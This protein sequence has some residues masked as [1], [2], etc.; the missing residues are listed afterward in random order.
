MASNPGCLI[1]GLYTHAGGF[2]FFHVR[3]KKGQLE[4]GR[5]YEVTRTATVERQKDK[6]DIC[7]CPVSRF[8]S[9]E[10]PGKRSV[11]EHKKIVDTEV[12]TWVKS[13]IEDTKD[14]GARILW[15]SAWGADAPTDNRKYQF[16]Y[17]GMKSQ[18][19]PDEPTKHFVVHYHNPDLHAFQLVD[20]LMGNTVIGAPATT[21]GVLNPRRIYLELMRASI[22]GLSLDHLEVIEA[23]DK[24]EPTKEVEV[25]SVFD[26]ELASNDY[27][28][29]KKR[30]RTTKWR[31]IKRP[32]PDQFWVESGVWEQGLRALVK[33]KNV[34]VTGPSGCG[35]TE[36][37]HLMAKALGL[38]TESINCGATT[39]PRDVFVGTVEFDPDKGTHLCRS[40]FAKFVGKERGV[41]L[42]DEITRGSRDANNILIPLLDRQA[43]IALDE[44]K[45][46]EVI[47]RGKHMAFAATANIGMEYTG[48]EALDI[49]LK[50]RFSI[51]VDLYFPPISNEVAVLV[52]RTGVEYGLAK[53]LCEV[54]EQQREAKKAGDFLEEISTRMLLESAELLVDGFDFT[55]SC[56]YTILNVFSSEG[57]E[58]SE[59]ARV[60]QMIQKRGL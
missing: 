50:Q 11:C 40:R 46:G 32:D 19:T 48:T 38:D 52:G 57:D 16:V 10:S 42:L 36:V 34:C 30:K 25:E 49:A 1:I 2:S 7:D 41:T 54:A 27:I 6:P 35:K 44:D 18:D 47:R 9:V 15:Q 26:E 5:Q 13:N 39:E 24:V 23:S 33:G 43:Y 53:K 14:A 20:M 45:G 3:R 17:V 4:T 8:R 56:K 55:E 21:D 12:T 28:H 22:N 51:T 60:M 58:S 29:D 59:R 37:V 31:E